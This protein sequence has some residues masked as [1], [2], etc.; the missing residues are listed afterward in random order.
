MGYTHYFPQT[1]SFTP[2]EWD[3]ITAIVTAMFHRCKQVAGPFGEDRPAVCNDKISFNG[4]GDEAHETCLI[5]RKHNPEFNFCKT[6]QKPYDRYVTATL[7]ICNHFAKDALTI[8]S[9]GEYS[10]WEEGLHLATIF[11]RGG[12]NTLIPIMIPSFLE[13]RNEKIIEN[14]TREIDEVIG[15]LEKLASNGNPLHFIVE[16]LKRHVDSIKKEYTNK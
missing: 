4:V 9:D 7:I 13:K 8:N 12:A 14:Y 10:D 11:I 2:D 3:K 5:T 1:R 15:S 6:N 16:Y